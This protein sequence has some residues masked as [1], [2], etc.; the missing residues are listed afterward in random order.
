MYKRLIHIKDNC[1]NGVV[2]DN[3]DDVANL[4]CF[5]NKSIDQ[6]VKEED[7]LIFPYSLNEYGDELGQ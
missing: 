1:V 5:L 2:I 6:L 3:P 7:L 4:S